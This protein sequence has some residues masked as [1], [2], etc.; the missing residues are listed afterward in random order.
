MDAVNVLQDRQN[1][2]TV[3]AENTPPPGVVVGQ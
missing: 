3:M 1:A 2:S